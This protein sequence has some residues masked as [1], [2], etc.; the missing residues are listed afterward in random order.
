L[1]IKK[2]RFSFDIPIQQLLAAIATT[3]T[4]MRI[5]VYGDDPPPTRRGRI[6]QGED[7]KMLEGPKQGKRRNGEKV[8]G[9]K[10]IAKHMVDHKDRGVAIAELKPI[11]TKAGLSEKSVSPQIDKLMKDGHA[12]RLRTGIYQITAKGVH[13]YG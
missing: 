3:N 2:V 4:A 7:V 6:T 9:L 10:L 12:K 5:D 13:A 11:I 8:S 1:P